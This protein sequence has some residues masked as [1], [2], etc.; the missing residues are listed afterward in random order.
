MDQT[1]FTVRVFSA[2]PLE[3][4][5]V[6]FFFSFSLLKRHRPFFFFLLS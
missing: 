2:R 1:E 4:R 6:S 5:T 3:L